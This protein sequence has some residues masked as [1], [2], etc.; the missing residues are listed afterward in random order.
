MVSTL[1]LYY[2]TIERF[3]HDF[4]HQIFGQRISEALK[5]QAPV[6]SGSISSCTAGNDTLHKRWGRCPGSPRIR[7]GGQ[8]GRG[9]AAPVRGAGSRGAWQACNRICRTYDT[10]L[11]AAS[12]DP[13]AGY[14]ET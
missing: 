7:G 8:L 11:G 2:L 12:E 13:D 1:F 9:T 10:R 14:A 4:I 5:G 6:G 3:H